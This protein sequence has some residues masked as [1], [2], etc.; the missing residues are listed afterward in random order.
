M[1]D[2]EALR[3]AMVD[4]QVRPSDVTRFGVIEAMLEVPRERFVPRAAREIAYAE[5][6]IPLAEGRVILE[7][8]TFAKM[9]E[10]A[11]IGPSDL[12][13]VV[14]CGFGYPAVVAS[15]LAAAV[16]AL[17]EDPTL[18]QH[19]ASLA[20]ELGAHNVIV[21]TGSLAAGAPQSGP[22]D[23][24]LVEGAVGREPSELIAQ[25]KDG[26]RLVAIRMDDVLGACRVWTRAGEVA[27][28][29]RAFDAAAPVLPGFDARK[30]F[31]F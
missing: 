30:T 22:Y 28:C 17:E 6:A 3:I 11:D 8:R 27:S 18:A 7:P 26:G 24:I 19:A 10:A 5:A 12:V 23:V 21:E 2:Y 16:V 1:I 25:L 20:S 29:R 31:A 9:L 14:G 4:R 13:L 15:R